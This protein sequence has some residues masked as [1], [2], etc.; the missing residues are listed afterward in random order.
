MPVHRHRAATRSRSP[1]FPAA[2]GRG[3]ARWTVCD[4]PPSRSAP[5]TRRHRGRSGQPCREGPR[6]DRV[7]AR[8]TTGAPLSGDRPPGIPW[9]ARR[10]SR[11]LRGLTIYAT[12][13]RTECFETAE[14]NRLTA[15]FALTRR[16]RLSFRSEFGADRGDARLFFLEFVLDELVDIVHFRCLRR[17]F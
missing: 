3:C 6:S 11:L 13:C 5:P 4:R 10:S 2:G 1:G 9:A 7:P 12:D 14:R 15:V 17:L 8:R 16:D